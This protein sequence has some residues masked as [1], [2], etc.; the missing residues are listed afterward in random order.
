MNEVTIYLA[1]NGTHECS[2]KKCPTIMREI[3][4]AGIIL[5]QP[6][7]EIYKIYCSFECF[8]EDMDKHLEIN[9]ANKVVDKINLLDKLTSGK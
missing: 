6:H 9:R 8:L 3:P 7:Q 5:S 2:N 4:A 1:L